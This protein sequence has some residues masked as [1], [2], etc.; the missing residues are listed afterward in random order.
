IN[1]KDYLLISFGSNWT[2]MMTMGILKWLS[3]LWSISGS[4]SFATSTT[5]SAIP[6]IATTKKSNLVNEFHPQEAGHTMNDKAKSIISTTIVVEKEDQLPTTVPLTP[7]FQVASSSRIENEH[8][9][10][11]NQVNSTLI[12]ILLVSLILAFQAIRVRD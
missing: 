4:Q 9:V 3:L 8:V 1:A 2:R 7:T 11:E 10:Q 12:L 5:Y 6:K